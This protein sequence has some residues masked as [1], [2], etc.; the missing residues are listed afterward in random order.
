MID[1]VATGADVQLE[2]PLG[3]ARPFGDIFH[4]EFLAAPGDEEPGDGLEDRLLT[5]LPDPILEPLPRIASRR[6][7]RLPGGP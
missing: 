3:D 6:R 1:Q 5:P 7:L 2:A 4:S